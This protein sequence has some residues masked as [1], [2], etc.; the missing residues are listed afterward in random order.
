MSSNDI[1]RKLK[2]GVAVNFWP[3]VVERTRK[4]DIGLGTDK[5]PPKRL[6]IVYHYYLLHYA[7]QTCFGKRPKHAKFETSLQFLPPRGH[8]V[9]YGYYQIYITTGGE[10]ALGV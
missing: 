8:C 6:A 7:T 9:S 4:D 2:L 3:D 10:L 5:G 1:D